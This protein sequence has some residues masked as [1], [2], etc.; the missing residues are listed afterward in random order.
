MNESSE[1]SRRNRLQQGRQETRTGIV[2]FRYRDYS[3]SLKTWMQVEPYGAS[4]ID[5]A[6]LYLG[7]GSNPVNLT[8]PLG[9][10][11]GLSIDTAIEATAVV[12]DQTIGNGGALDRAA[13]FF[14][15]WSDVLTLGQSYLVRASIIHAVYGTWDDGVDRSSEEYWAGIEAGVYHAT[16][17]IGAFRA[18]AARAAAGRA[19]CG[20]T[21]ARVVPNPHGKLGSPAHR[22]KVAERAAELESQ[23]YRITGGGGRLP[24]RAVGDAI[25]GR[26]YPDISAMDRIGRPYYENIGKVTGAG[27]PAARE[28]RALDHIERLTGIRPVFTPYK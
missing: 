22:A 1:S 10:A 15:G 13:N 26:R 25:R 7:L 5:G 11:P 3:T 9:L 27:K 23:G 28:I 2:Y 17:I 16:G 4:Y 8:D 6:N 12:G 24:E 14:G 20:E 19:P 18:V 21:A